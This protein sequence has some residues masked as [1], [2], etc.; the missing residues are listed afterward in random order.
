[1]SQP[2]LTKPGVTDC[3]W[4][5][6]VCTSD[7]TAIEFHEN[8]LD[9]KDTAL[10]NLAPTASVYVVQVHHHGEMSYR[11][12]TS[13]GNMVVTVVVQLD[14]Q[15]RRAIARYNGSRSRSA[16]ASTLSMLLAGV[17]Q[18]LRDNCKKATPEPEIHDEVTKNGARP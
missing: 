5:H 4:A 15:T 9:A 14:A 18:D 10:M 7:A 12:R 17:L 3:E 2:K 16:V 8:E 13:D 11:S 6:V 1:M